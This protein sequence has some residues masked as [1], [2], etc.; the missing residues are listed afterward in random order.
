MIQAHM[1]TCSGGTTCLVTKYIPP[2]VGYAETS[3][4]TGELENNLF[5]R[6]SC[7][8]E[9]AIHMAMQE[10]MNQHQTAVAGPPALMGLPKVAGTEP[11]T[12]KMEMAYEMVDHLV[13]SRR[14]SCSRG[15]GWVRRDRMR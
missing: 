8:P 11:K 12:P 2:A 9:L 14:N 3:S 1:A 7:L 5:A 10:P 4:E 6:E 15:Q 13:N